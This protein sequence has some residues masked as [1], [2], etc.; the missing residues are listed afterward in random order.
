MA[1]EVVVSTVLG[2]LADLVFEEANFLQEVK[3]QVEWIK[4]ELQGMICFLRDANEKQEG[5]TRVKNWIAKIQDMAYN[6]EDIIDIVIMRKEEEKN[7]KTIKK[8][9]SI[10]SDMKA[11]HEVGDELVRIRTKHHEISERRG[12]LKTLK[13]QLVNNDCGWRVVSI[14]GMGGLGKTTLAKKVYNS[15]D[16]I[17]HFGQCCAWIYVSQVY[18]AKG[19]LEDIWKMVKDFTKDN[20]TVGPIEEKIS[21]KLRHR[22]L[23][24]MDDVWDVD[25]W[26]CVKA[27]FSDLGNGGR[28]L[29]TTRNRDVAL[30]AD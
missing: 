22:Y 7:R 4:V 9:T 25:V 8:Y 1:V 30:H 23:V 15:K 21:K 2:K 3:N 24:V 20:S 19:L 29:L 18:S 6:V 26:N 17:E 14:V 28:M 27:A 12:D 16:A 13:Q 5:D 11:R 10:F